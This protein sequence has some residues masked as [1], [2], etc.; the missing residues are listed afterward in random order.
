MHVHPVHPPGYATG[1]VVPAA[2]ATWA[3]GPVRLPYA[4]VDFIPQSW[5]YN[6]LKVTF[7]DTK[8]IACNLP[9]RPLAGTLY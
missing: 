9:A 2:R 8:Y 3:G 6:P 4:G 5:I 1:V 7:T